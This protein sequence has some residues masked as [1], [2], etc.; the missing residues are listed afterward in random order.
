MNRKEIEPPQGG[1]TKAGESKMTVRRADMMARGT[2]IR[3]KT[4]RIA[5]LRG[6]GYI[7]VMTWSTGLRPRLRNSAP[8][9]G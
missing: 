9:G 2:A 3:E 5:S 1:D 6:L 8:C 4:G 7:A